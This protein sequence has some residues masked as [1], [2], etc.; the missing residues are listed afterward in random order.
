MEGSSGSPGPEAGKSTIG[1]FVLAMEEP[2]VSAGPF[3]DSDT[4]TLYQVRNLE[5]WSYGD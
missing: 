4:D 1:L 5:V 2:I 3:A